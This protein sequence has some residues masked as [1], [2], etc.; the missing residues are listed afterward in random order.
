MSITFIIFIVLQILAFA[1]FLEV[2]RRLRQRT[3]EYPLKDTSETLPFGF[4]RLSHIVLIYITLY[5]LWVLL[6]F[7]LYFNW[8]NVSA[9]LS[10][11]TAE[12]LNL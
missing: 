2:M 12:T 3:R 10:T 6:S 9:A 4:V 8:L 1:Y 7:W 11:P 5:L